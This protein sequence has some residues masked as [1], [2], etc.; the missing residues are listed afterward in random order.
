MYHVSQ[1]MIEEKLMFLEEITSFYH[2]QNSWTTYTEKLALER[3]THIMI[4]LV[5]DIGN[6]LIDGF[7]MRDP[8]SYQDII[9]ILLDEKV[10]DDSLAKKLT[11]IISLRDSIVRDYTNVDHHQVLQTLELSSCALPLFVQNVK[12]YL[13]NDQGHLTTFIRQ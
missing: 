4:E 12:R 13:K 2:N 9:S 10:I 8:G 3:I 11:F 5:I 6:G 7:I 1:K